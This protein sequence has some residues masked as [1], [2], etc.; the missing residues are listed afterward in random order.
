MR[1]SP[2]ID[3]RSD[4]RHSGRL[5]AGSA[6][7]RIGALDSSAVARPIL[8]RDAQIARS[9]RPTRLRVAETRSSQPL[10]SS[11]LKPEPAAK[12]P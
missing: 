3:D 8:S 4:E 11:L 6:H 5:S 9:Y 10:R 7:A 12:S 2:P 1:P